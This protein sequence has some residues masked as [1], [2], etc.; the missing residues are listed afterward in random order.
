[1]K[2]VTE[3]LMSELVTEFIKTNNKQPTHIVMTT[4]QQEVLSDSM[5]TKVR[6]GAPGSD[7]QSQI[8][9]ISTPDG[10]VLD[11]LPVVYTALRSGSTKPVDFPVVVSL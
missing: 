3:E 10:L 8:V 2:I 6:I 4:E 7:G 9:T 5:R 11:I 1:M